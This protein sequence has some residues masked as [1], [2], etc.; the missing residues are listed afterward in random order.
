MPKYKI[1]EVSF[2]VLQDATL[3]D[4]ERQTHISVTGQREHVWKLGLGPCGREVDTL[5]Y[6]IN[7]AALTVRQISYPKGFQ[8]AHDACMKD[9]S[10]PRTEHHRP[11]VA[12]RRTLYYK[13][14]EDVKK[15]HFV[16]PLETIVGRIRVLEV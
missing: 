11:D 15:E 8:E 14:L 12:G 4:P 2:K 7:V 9:I 1:R 10:R 5:E 3:I 13:L 6:D 16:Y